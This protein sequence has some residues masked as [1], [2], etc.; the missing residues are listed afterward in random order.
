MF[1]R[2]VFFW[3]GKG[4]FFVQCAAKGA[5]LES[6][7]ILRE[8]QPSSVSCIIQQFERGLIP[9]LITHRESS[10]VGGRSPQVGNEGNVEQV[11]QVEP[12]VQYKPPGLPVLWHEAGFTAARKRKRVDEKEPE[13]HDNA[14][15]NAPPQLLVHHRLGLLF[16]VDE[17]LHCR[18]QR[19]KGPHVKCRQ[20]SGKWENNEKDERTG[21]VRSD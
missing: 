10:V 1:R 13:N 17:V 8:L 14:D 15:Q 4:I 3:S 19:I 2:I 7:V 6:I 12:T 9:Y 21:T 20:C 5:N 18:I 16:P 11:H